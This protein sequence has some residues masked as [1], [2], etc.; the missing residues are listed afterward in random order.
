M[1]HEIVESEEYFEVHFTH[2]GKTWH[3]LGFKMT[4]P[5]AL[6]IFN[7]FSPKFREQNYR[8]VRCVAKIERFRVFETSPD[9]V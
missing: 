6:R 4:S 9:A 5:V 1:D 7:M 8:M 2:D 3:N